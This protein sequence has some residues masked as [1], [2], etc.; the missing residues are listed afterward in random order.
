[1]RKIVSFKRFFSAC[2]QPY[3]SA[4]RISHLL[5]R[6]IVSLSVLIILLQPAWVALCSPVSC[7]ASG[8]ALRAFYWWW[9]LSSALILT[10]FYLNVIMVGLMFKQTETDAKMKRCL[11]SNRN[12][13]TSFAMFY[14]FFWLFIPAYLLIFAS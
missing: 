11:M 7:A 3:P 8:A 14:V 5:L 4:L 2:P 10:H 1:M 12:K 9:G 6:L 13:D